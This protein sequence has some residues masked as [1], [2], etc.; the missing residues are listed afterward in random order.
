MLNSERRFPKREPVWKP[1]LDIDCSL[2]SSGGTC[3]ATPPPG[4]RPEP[5]SPLHK[6]S[7]WNPLV[8]ILPAGRFQTEV[9]SLI[10]NSFLSYS[11]GGFQRDI[12]VGHSP[13][14]SRTT[15]H[16]QW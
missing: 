2:F 11:C 9:M 8:R 12:P 6:T 16:R 5:V 14:F 1:L 10:W 3:P 4:P 7:D 15:S 13:N